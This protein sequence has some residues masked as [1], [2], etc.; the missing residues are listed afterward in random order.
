MIGTRKQL[1]Y[2]SPL[3]PFVVLHDPSSKQLEFG[4]I[5]KSQDA[6]H[7]TA[8]SYVETLLPSSRHQFLSLYS[9]TCEIYI[10][11]LWHITSTSCPDAVVASCGCGSQRDSELIFQVFYKGDQQLAFI[12]LDLSL[13][14]DTSKSCFKVE[15]VIQNVLCISPVDFLPD[16]DS[17][18]L[19]ASLPFASSRSPTLEYLK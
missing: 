4:I 3:T 9:K 8:D 12:R 19:M 10:E 11:N 15:D 6:A 18:N 17:Q 1:L 13:L 7:E 2:C 16:H 5:K 14:G